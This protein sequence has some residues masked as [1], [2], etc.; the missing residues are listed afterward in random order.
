MLTELFGNVPKTIV[1]VA[2]SPFSLVVKPAT[3]S[4]VITPGGGTSLSVFVTATSAG[5]I[6]A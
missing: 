4:T 6:A 3:G 1:K 2:E 5:S